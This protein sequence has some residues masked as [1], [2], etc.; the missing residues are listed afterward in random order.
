MRHGDE[1]NCEA[2]GASAFVV[3]KPRM[4]GWNKLGDE[5]VCSA[6]GAKIADVLQTEEKPRE[7]SEKASS[8]LLGFLG[9]EQEEKKEIVATEDEKHF[10]RDC[11]HLVR[12]PF[13]FRCD[14]HKK[15][16]NPMDDCPDFIRRSRGE[17]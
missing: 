6:C 11:G 7:K 1:V 3:K 12:H 17:S 4:D 8:A 5:F 15:D 13:L 9:M 2:C 10:C 16:V 14:L